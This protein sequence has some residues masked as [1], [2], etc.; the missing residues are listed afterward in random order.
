MPSPEPS[1][2]DTARPDCEWPGCK[3]ESVLR[4][5]HHK[6]NFCFHHHS[7]HNDGHHC[8]WGPSPRKFQQPAKKAKEQQP[9][10]QM[11]FTF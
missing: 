4:C 1:A 2:P 8:F 11:E 3:A 6:Q 5:K 10:A 9:T 7:E